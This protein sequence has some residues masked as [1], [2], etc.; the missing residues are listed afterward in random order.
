[1]VAPANTRLPEIRQDLVLYPDQYGVGGTPAW[2]VHDRSVNRFF[3]LGWQESE[4][5]SR[6]DCS[7]DGHTL[8]AEICQET[9]LKV[10]AADVLSFIRFLEKNSLTQPASWQEVAEKQ[11]IERGWF[12][13]LF[14]NYLHFKI[15]LLRPDFL[16]EKLAPWVRPLFM[17]GFL[18]L[19]LAVGLVGLFLASRQWESFVNGFPYLLSL[20]GAVLLGLAIFLAKFIHELGHSCA[21][22]RYGCR[23]PTMGVAF[24]VLWPVLYADSSESWKL[25]SNKKRM[26]VAA[27]GMLAELILAAFAIFAWNFA[28]DGVGRNILLVLATVTWSWGLLINANP[29]LRFDGYYLLSDWLQIANL[30][31]RAFA[32]GRWQLR[33]VLLGIDIPSPEQFQPALGRF[34]IGFAWS[35]WIFRFLLFLGIALLVYNF[36]F[37]LLGLVLML[38]E[39]YWFLLRP[40]INELRG[41]LVHKGQVAT[42]SAAILLLLLVTFVGIIAIPWPTQIA[43]P[44]L[45]H[46][47]S[48]ARI[49]AP[50]GGQV[51][52]VAVKV[53]DMVKKGQLL[54][55]LQSP[56]LEQQLAIKQ[57]EIARLNAEITALAT[58]TASMADHRAALKR[59][60]TAKS[61]ENA[62]LTSKKALQIK[63][64]IPGIIT[65]IT[66][67]IKPGLWLPQGELLAHI[68]QPFSEIVH[69]YLPENQQNRLIPGSFGHF[70]ADSNHRELL[71]VQLTTINT[72]ATTNLQNRPLASTFNGPIAVRQS[73]QD[74]LVPES[75]IYRL[76]LVPTQP[77]QPPSSMVKRG[78]T[79]LTAKPESLLQRGWNRLLAVLIRESGL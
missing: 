29:M 62:L 76:T 3:R 71:P 57:F 61:Q 64:S 65:K 40:I 21:A 38:A 50:A 24:L 60:A 26:V 49:Y 58:K 56:D 1:M 67:G 79:I 28:P 35:T 46:S 44:S 74:R 19:V 72:Y 42:G 77:S 9:T 55:G 23:V 5:L 13:R 66:T 33:R 22:H 30:Q 17:P 68:Q 48:S 36:F 69:A 8:A 47:A 52:T 18:L 63:S 41:W 25:V 51:A 70:V 4:M 15:P 53:G 54:F 75:A 59:L 12:L 37:K 7:K 43:L 73:R 6:W 14:H 20:H 39:I 16:L 32:M 78:V 10:S 31:D 45:M 11:P 27:S 34:L 2:V